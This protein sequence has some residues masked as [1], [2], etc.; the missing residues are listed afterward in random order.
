MA[1]PLTKKYLTELLEQ[2]GVDHPS[3]DKDTHLT[4]FNEGRRAIGLRILADIKRA[5]S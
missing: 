5:E 4:A 3:F 1:G 2:C